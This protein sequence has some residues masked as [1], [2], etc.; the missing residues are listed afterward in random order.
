MTNDNG[1]N[2]TNAI[3]DHDTLITY[4]THI[5]YTEITYKEIVIMKS[6][7]VYEN[8]LPCLLPDPINLLL[9]VFG[10]YSYIVIPST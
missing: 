8:C 4:N 6:I 2:N 10:N 3:T 1:T 9:S 5:P 7:L